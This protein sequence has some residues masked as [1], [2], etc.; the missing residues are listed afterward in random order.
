MKQFDVIVVGGG[1]AGLIAAGT[2]AKNGAQVL[3]AERNSR[4]AR[5]VMITGKGRCNVTNDCS[6][7]VFLQNVCSNSKFLFGAIHRFPPQR[8]MALLESLGVP[9]KVERGN[10]VFPVSDQ[11][12]DV[13][14]AL[15]SFAK[16]AGVVFVQQRI[17][18]LLVVDGTVTGVGCEDGAVFSAP[19]V[20]V[21]TGGKSYPLTGSTGDGY[22]LATQAG[23]TVTPAMPSL[24][25]I[26]TK[27][28]WCRE[29]M[30]LSLKN[31]T[32]TLWEKGRK[33]P[34]YTELGEMLFTHFGVSGPLVL[35]ASTYL[36]KDLSQYQLEID[37]KPALDNRQLEQRILRDFQ[38]N[39]NRDFFNSLSELLPRKLIPV[40]VRLSEIP[41]E[42]KVH[43]VTR[44]QREKLCGIIKHLA[45]TPK[46]LLPIEEAI[47]TAGGVQ[48]KEVNPH[49][50]E[51]KLCQGLYFAGEVLDLDARTG[52][53]NLQIA[54]CT[55]FVAGE[56]VGKEDVSC[57]Q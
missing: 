26:E 38:V 7:E 51:S 16:K 24:I 27:E 31:V 30:G 46:G 4:M 39:S 52:G 37:L 40:I 35:T 54:F 49:T 28:D 5:K 10:R 55:G 33:K 47:V 12:V 18:Q 25:P 21:A 6:E 1:A 57:T 44:E 45:L 17:S 19:K 11:A 43:Q 20:I 15:V 32:L 53:F 2:A 36:K 50:M 34:L 41:P 23:H 9:L 14:D 13:V 22:Q 29:C 42:Q 48:T 8:T 3:L 56:S